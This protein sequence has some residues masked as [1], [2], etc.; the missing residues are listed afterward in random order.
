MWRT[1]ARTSTAT[2]SASPSTRTPGATVYQ[3]PIT[4]TAASTARSRSAPSGVTTDE[5]V[6][7][8]LRRH[9]RRPDQPRRPRQRRGRDR[10]RQPVR[11]PR[12][13]G[14]VRP[15]TLPAGTRLHVVDA[16]DPG[17]RRRGA[18][19]VQVAGSTTRR[20]PATCSPPTSPRA[21]AAPRSSGSSTR[22]R[23]FSPNGDG[24][25]DTPTLRGRFTE[26]VA[27]TLQ[28]P[29]RRGPR[30]VRRRPG[31]GSHVQ[32]RL[33]RASSAA[34][35]S[36]DGTY[37]VERQR[38]STRGAT[39]RRS[40]TRAARRRH[41]RARAWP[42]SP[43]RADT[44]QWFSPNGDGCPR[45]GQPDGHELARP[46]R[47]SARVVDAGGAPSQAAGPSP[48]GPARPR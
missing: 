43:R 2:S 24:R 42:A 5:V 25:V 26:S 18:T 35:R 11:R 1:D 16:A 27:W 37:T 32:R 3:D 29:R 21:T 6:S 23:P 39:A 31:T 46:A 20:S 34:T 47:S 17:D 14:R 9:G 22:A 40:R 38:A 4:P 36:P 15:T 10:R 45:H 12:H 8:R 7:G 30:A 19:L 41:R 28:R 13:H 44:T 33:G 48:T